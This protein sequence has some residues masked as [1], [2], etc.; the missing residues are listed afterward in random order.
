[1]YIGNKK[2]DLNSPTYFIA[3]IGSNFDGDIE[4][5]KSLIWLAKESGADAAKFQHYT[6]DT[7]VSNYEFTNLKNA[8]HQSDWKK[9]V[10]EVYKRAELNLEW[11]GVLAAE[12]KKAQ[13]DFFTSPYAY[14]LA[15]YVESFIPAYKIGSGDITWIDYLKYVASKGKPIIL[16]TG[17]STQDEVDRA[18]NAVLGIT[19]ELVLMQCNTNYSG[20]PENAKYMNLRVLSTFSIQYPGVVLG[21]SDHS[22]G[23]VSILGA[24][25]L[26]ARV[27]ERHFTDDA[28]REGPDHP[29]ST[30]AK[31][32]RNMM[33]LARELEGMLGD[34]IKRVEKNE[35]EARIVQRRSICAK[36]DLQEGH[37]LGVEDLD[38]LR[39]CTNNG[40][41]PSEMNSLIGK[42]L[43][44]SVEKGQS[45][46]KTMF[47]D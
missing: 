28:S 13:I 23:A 24:I 46:L 33:R 3:E 6:A 21:L 39:P 41:A 11:T 19:S 40:F 14:Y 15:D 7:L 8:S 18:V 36:N 44:E 4:R 22:V 25:A 17:A 45:F 37:V 12:A 5:A 26:G 16:A 2:I 43:I 20:N 42:K 31:S 34:G 32:W 10:Y 47:H 9:S 27:I 30:D 29:F 38:Y 1:M 35:E